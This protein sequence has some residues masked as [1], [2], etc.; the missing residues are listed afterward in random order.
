MAQMVQWGLDKGEAMEAPSE[1]R[2]RLSIDVAPELR[3]RLKIAAAS[4]DLSVRD[5]VETI[6]RRALEAEERGET[7]SDQVFWSRLSARSFA[8]DWESEEDQAYDRLS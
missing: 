3:R 1:R 8:R 6:L 7:L 4:R 2:A 5:Y